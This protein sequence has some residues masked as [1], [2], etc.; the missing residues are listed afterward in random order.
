[1]TSQI[2]PS[3]DVNST[4]IERFAEAVAGVAEV[5]TDPAILTERGHDFWGFGGAA[6]LLLRPHNRDEIAEIMRV[7]TEH[8]S[9]SCPAAAR[10]TAR[11]G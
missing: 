9:R 11:Q 4:S 5:V 8:P 10:R 6:E 1:M 7:A 2:A 3:I